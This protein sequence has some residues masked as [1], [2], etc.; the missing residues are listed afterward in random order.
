MFRNRLGISSSCK[1][2]NQYLSVLFLFMF[3]L[4]VPKFSHAFSLMAK[5]SAKFSY[6]KSNVGSTSS[7]NIKSN[8]NNFGLDINLVL[9]VGIFFGVSVD[10]GYSYLNSFSKNGAKISELT[11]TLGLGINLGFWLSGFYISATYLP[12]ISGSVLNDVKMNKAKGVVGQIGY[13]MNLIDLISILPSSWP[14]FGLGPSL[15]YKI[16]NQTFLETVKRD[17]A[18]I[19][20]DDGTTT[21]MSLFLDLVMVF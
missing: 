19:L 21:E 20:N 13:S 8:I 11:K 5:S 17:A 4:A 10:K 1:K 3:C 6:I 7:R 15:R 12:V 14:H 16:T 18:G 9:P 2:T